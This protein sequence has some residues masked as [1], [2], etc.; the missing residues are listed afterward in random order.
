MEVQCHTANALTDDAPDSRHGRRARR[1]SERL[2]MQVSQTTAPDGAV[3]A[4]PL[5]AEFRAME[6]LNI[7]KGRFFA[8]PR[9]KSG[10][11]HR[12]RRNEAPG[13]SDGRVLDGKRE[14]VPALAVLMAC[15]LAMLPET[16]HAQSAEPDTLTTTWSK[17]YW[18]G[19]S[20]N[21]ATSPW[22]GGSGS[23]DLTRPLWA[24]SSNP[25]A[26]RAWPSNGAVA[27]FG[28]QY[29]S[30]MTL[31]T[32]I[33]VSGFEIQLPSLGWPVGSPANDGTTFAVPPGSDGGGSFLIP[34]GGNIVIDSRNDETEYTVFVVDIKDA[35]N[36]FFARDPST[37]EIKSGY[38]RFDGQKSYRGPTVVDSGAGLALNTDET[39][40]IFPAMAG[41][42][43][44]ESESKLAMTITQTEN[45][46]PFPFTPMTIATAN[47]PA[48]PSP[49]IILACFS[50]PQTLPLVNVGDQ[51][52]RNSGSLFVDD[53]ALNMQNNATVPAT[54]SVR[55]P[56][57]EGEYSFQLSGTGTVG[58]DVSRH[59][60][61]NSILSPGAPTDQLSLGYVAFNG[62]LHLDNDSNIFIDIGA[63]GTSNGFMDGM[64]Y[65]YVL[66]D[67]ALYINNDDGPVEIS[68]YGN[69]VGTYLIIKSYYIYIE[70]DEYGAFTV[71]GN[72][73]SKDYNVSIDTSGPASLVKLTISE[74]MVPPADLGGEDSE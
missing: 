64:N 61:A 24:N 63:R 54:I 26:A 47:L 15:G 6:H 1:P 66:V 42:M 35:P 39:T 9:K 51:F 38:V 13:R 72:D 19:A 5:S 53:C 7:V 52:E 27:V 2:H 4:R 32:D 30:R 45:G 28:G 60:L 67:N 46:D 41:G 34:R 17:Y 10:R 33:H 22:V 69:T 58:T 8:Q 57:E 23:W 37:V 40:G 71:V 21:P 68:V 73:N 3:A 11:P 49:E 74:K 59:N 65:D 56:G 43:I 48:G 62:N 14:A 44:L 70:G 31:N 16:G 55:P 50:N 20:N 18:N 29:Y 25:T 36:G 12:R